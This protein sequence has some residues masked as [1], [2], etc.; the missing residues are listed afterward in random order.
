MTDGIQFIPITIYEMPSEIFGG[1][2]Y[3]LALFQETDFEEWLM[4]FD[5]SLSFQN[6]RKKSLYEVFS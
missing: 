6:I 5:V 2:Y 1:F 4:S 3:R